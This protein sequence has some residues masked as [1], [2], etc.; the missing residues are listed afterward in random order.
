MH[1]SQ[2]INATAIA[3]SLLAASAASSQQIDT[4]RGGRADI[5]KLEYESK[6]AACHGV[7]GE[8]DG[9]M[10]LFLTQK[11]ADLTKIA[12]INN[13]ILPAAEMYDVIVADK[14]VPSH[15]SR[16][17]PVWGREFRVEAAGAPR[18]G[19]APNDRESYMRARVLA[20]IE[21]I[22]RLQVK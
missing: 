22:G 5:G 14:K 15:G 21:Y 3:A 4:P 7:K 11:V 17:M 9:P 2:I 10:A 16:E 1:L 20:I 19:S 6:C 13:G 12:K 18:D 8:G